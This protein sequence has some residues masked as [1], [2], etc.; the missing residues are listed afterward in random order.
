MKKTIKFTLK[1]KSDEVEKL[2]RKCSNF[3]KSNGILDDTVQSQVMVVRE[4]VKNGLKYGVVNKL[5]NWITVQIHINKSQIVVEVMN[6]INETN[7]HKLKELDETIQWIRGYQDPYQ[8]YILRLKEASGKSINGKANGLNL[9]RIAYK[10]NAILDFFVSE[11]NILNLLAV[12]NLDSD[13]RN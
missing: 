6:P 10:A 1:P 12:R 3:L 8:A 11:D 5:E 2:I 4:L 13:C 9:V 7:L